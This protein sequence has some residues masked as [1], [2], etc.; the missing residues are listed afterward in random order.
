MNQ[1]GLNYL[2]EI[3]YIQ[4]YIYGSLLC[5]H[6]SPK[7]PGLQIIRKEEEEKPTPRQAFTI[8]FF[9]ASLVLVPLIIAVTILG[10]LWVVFDTTD[11]TG[12]YIGIGIGLL[13]SMV[14]S[15]IFM[16]LATR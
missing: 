1:T 11:T 14:L 3:R 13:I 2:N 6:M 15:F 4:T 8:G 9:L 10:K 16:K 5:M 12:I 7:T